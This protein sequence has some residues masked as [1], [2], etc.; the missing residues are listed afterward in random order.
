M[1]TT[2][3]KSEVTVKLSYFEGG[4]DVV[5][6]ESTRKVDTFVK[7][8]NEF[9]NE[10]NLLTFAFPNNV[11]TVSV[12]GMEIDFSGGKFAPKTSTFISFVA[13]KLLGGFAEKEAKKEM[14]KKVS[15]EL[16][17]DKNIVEIAE[18]LHNIESMSKL[19][20]YN[21]GVKKQLLIETNVKD[22]K[23]KTI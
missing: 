12:N 2:D 6:L 21:F 14:I 20:L 5:V 11:F 1:N 10:C 18:V 19:E 3:K 7:S 16:L 22:A 13:S 8:F 23:Y 9:K 15:T 17:K 4:K